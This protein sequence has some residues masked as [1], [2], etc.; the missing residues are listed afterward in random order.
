M[1]KEVRLPSGAILE[2]TTPYMWIYIY[3]DQKGKLDDTCQ[4]YLFRQ[5]AAYERFI[6]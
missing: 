4:Y 2:I 5:I 1:T 3:A 6:R